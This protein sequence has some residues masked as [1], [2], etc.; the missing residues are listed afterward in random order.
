MNVVTI[1]T[2]PPDEPC[3]RD[4]LREMK[5][6]ITAAVDDPAQHDWDV[7]LKQVECSL[8]KDLSFIATSHFMEW[9]FSS[10]PIAKFL[11]NHFGNYDRTCFMVYRTNRTPTK[12]CM[13]AGAT[14]Q[15]FMKFAK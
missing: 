11:G 10:L 13:N 3:G 14:L 6:K 4:V 7:H 12:T 15:G 5:R 8:N 1:S 2:D 9:N